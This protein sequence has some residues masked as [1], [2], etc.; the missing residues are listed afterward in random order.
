M[1]SPT[2]K[3]TRCRT[4]SREHVQHVGLVLGGVGAAGHA[5]AAVGAR[6][7]AGVVPGGDGVEA[8]RIGSAEQPVELEVAVALDARVRR[9][10]GSVVGHVGRHHV[11]VEVVA[12]VE[13]VVLDAEAA[14]PPRGRRRRR[15]PSSSRSRTRRPTA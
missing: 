11:L 10:A 5:S 3:R 9:A 1:R 15:P 2:G 13:H 6:H 12:E 7:D 8:E 4:S 14:A